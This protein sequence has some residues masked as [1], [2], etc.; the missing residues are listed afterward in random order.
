MRRS[1]GSVKNKGGKLFIFS[2]F[3]LG[4][5]GLY[6][7]DTK[8]KRRYSFY[9]SFFQSGMDNKMLC[10]YAFSRKKN[11]FE[12]GDFS[13]KEE[14]KE[15]QIIRGNIKMLKPGDLNTLYSEIEKYSNYS[16]KN[17]YNGIYLIIDFER[18]RKE[19]IKDII[20]LEEKL[21][22]SS[23]DIALTLVC[24][25]NMDYIEQNFIDTITKLHHKVIISTHGCEHSIFF[26]NTPEHDIFP[27]ENIKIISSEVMEQS[28]KKALPIIILSMLKLKPMSGFDVI[29]SLVQNFN[30]FLS[31]GTV[32]PILY[33]MKEGGH[34]RVIIKSDNKTKLYVPTEKSDDYIEKKIKEYLNA[35]KKI[36]GFI[37]RSL[38]ENI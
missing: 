7:Y 4:S 31:Q 36:I 3:H 20:N 6:L 25:Y 21:H 8:E 32:Y 11:K 30:I 2:N 22:S 16:K 34:L 12:F 33:S 17:H 19:I 23:S 26:F 10:I 13:G 29:K 1:N 37:S 27:S 28:I 5:H 35:Q 14:F 9:N 18:L 24:S 15:I 38:E